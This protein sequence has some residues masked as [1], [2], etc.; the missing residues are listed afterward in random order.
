MVTIVV[1]R[2]SPRPK[3]SSSIRLKRMSLRG[4]SNDRREFELTKQSL[5]DCF[6]E[7][8]RYSSAILLA[9][10]VTITLGYVVNEFALPRLRFHTPRRHDEEAPSPGRSLAHVP[11]SH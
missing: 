5:R 10:T 7:L 6:G 9:M 1:A 3:D 2:R 11:T 8:L 4:N